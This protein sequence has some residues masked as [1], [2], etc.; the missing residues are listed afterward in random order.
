VDRAWGVGTYCTHLELAQGQREEKKSGDQWQC[1]S[2]EASRQHGRRGGSSTPG[3]C[4]R[5]QFCAWSEVSSP[6]AFNDQSTDFTA[7]K[8][9]GGPAYISPL[10]AGVVIP[11]LLDLLSPSE[12]SPQAILAALR[13]LNS[14]ADSL[15]L[16][17]C[18]PD[19]TEDGLPLLLYTEQHL[20][21]L[22]HLL[23]Q[24]PSSQLNQ[25]QAS[26]A[27]A[28]ITKTCRKEWQ[29]KILTQVGVLEALATQLSFFIK[30]TGGCRIAR[31][32]VISRGGNFD[33]LP[34]AFERSGLASILEAVGT[35]VQNSKYRAIQFLAAP[36]FTAVLPIAEPDEASGTEKRANIWTSN[37][38]STPS[39]YLTSPNPLETLIPQLP[40]LSHQSSAGAAPNYLP[41]GAT[42]GLGN[43]SQ[44]SR[45]FGSAIEVLQSQGYDLNKGDENSLI[46]WL[47]YLARAESGAIRL[48]AAWVLAIFYRLGLADRR[49]EAGFAYLLMPILVRMLEKDPKAS[50][51]DRSLSDARMLRSSDWLIKEQAPA[52]LAMLAV[53][54]PELQRAAVDAGA[55]KRL[56]QLLKESYDPLPP[57]SS[58][59]LWTP[60]SS[61]LDSPEDM[62]KSSRLGASGLSPI[63]Y[64]VT[65]MREEV[66][67]GLAAIASLKDE[68]RKAIIDNGVVPFVI[69]S[70]KPSNVISSSGVPEVQGDEASKGRKAL[71]GNPR[72]VILAAC[73]A[74]RGL[75]R[76]VSTLR[77]SLMD[78]GL[79]APL[80]VLL[81]HQDMD[82]QVAATAVICNLVLEFSPMREVS[83]CFCCPVIY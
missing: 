29:R 35:I 37:L 31:N 38:F 30:A 55:I 11:P 16:E 25:Q 44:L 46:S 78:A 66:L 65:R 74:A 23:S 15:C 52:V 27:A 24:D 19:L 1:S 73:A 36:S 22:T 59:T 51:T 10:N 80:F 79:A 8:I 40:I 50:S 77:T 48:M 82:I 68:Y 76:S 4:D 61:D 28:L 3:D 2:S 63:A 75:S 41:P 72:S 39:N 21:S 9:I 33:M 64:H 81:K 67:K 34:S 7:I 62:S 14:I 43:L 57:R 47:I 56:S 18:T 83:I 32:G 20:T 5:R 71:E 12:S 54:S 70:L 60:Q 58:L 53:E 13:T 26:L 6:I 42:G 45:S 49:R 69:E 17:P